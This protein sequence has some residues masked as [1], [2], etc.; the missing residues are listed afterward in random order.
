MDPGTWGWHE[1]IRKSIEEL[2]SDKPTQINLKIGQQFKHE[3]YTYRFEIT[4]IKILD[5]KPDYNESL[6][7]SA[8]IHITTYIP[9]S[10]DNKAIKIKD[11]TI[12]PK[13]INT[14]KWLLI[15]GSE[16]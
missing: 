13:V 3:L 10:T 2:T 5:E 15:N 4:D 12:R 7:S 16:R 1:R 9:N 6:Y 8:E 14:D 11:Y